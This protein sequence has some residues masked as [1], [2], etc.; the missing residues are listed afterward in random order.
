MPDVRD[1]PEQQMNNLSTYYKVEVELPK[2]ISLH[3]NSNVPRDEFLRGCSNVLSRNQKNLGFLGLLEGS[4]TIE[5]Q[6][7]D[8]AMA[9]ENRDGVSELPILNICFYFESAIGAQR[10]KSE[11]S[12]TLDK[13]TPIQLEIETTEDW[14][15]KWRDH[16]KGESILPFWRITPIWQKGI[17]KPK[18]S[19]IEILMNPS[20]GFGTGNHPTTQLCLEALG[21]ESLKGKKVL[22]FGSGSGILAVAA[23]KLG[24]KVDAV[25][26]DDMALQSAKDCAQINEVKDQISFSEEL[27]DENKYDVIV[28]NILMSVLVE[29][30][31]R[32][33]DLLNDNGVLILSGLLNENLKE[34]TEAYSSCFH[35]KWGKP[36]TITS[37]SKDDWNRIVFK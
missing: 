10:W 27:K 7:Y 8:E 4:L 21:D 15:E 22:D 3:S 26:I 14:N 24:A 1:F 30:A 5:T 35:A 17:E 20:L 33:V 25:E 2:K 23:A 29:F 32:L 16:F 37:S 11:L 12:T 36:P 19:E 18:P 34:T 31:P 13:K 28:S 9:P 6:T